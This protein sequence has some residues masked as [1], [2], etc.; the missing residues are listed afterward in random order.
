MADSGAL[1]ADRVSAINGCVRGQNKARYT[2]S[3]RLCIIQMMASWRHKS[4]Y[5]RMDA[6]DSIQLHAINLAHETSSFSSPAIRR[7][8]DQT[9]PLAS[10]TYGYGATTRQRNGVGWVTFQRAPSFTNVNYVGL[11]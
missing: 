9:N 3:D 4:L 2:K 5:A 6:S 8:D 7:A 10:R 11:L 1:D